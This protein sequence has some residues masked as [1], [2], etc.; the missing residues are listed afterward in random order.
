MTIVDVVSY[1]DLTIGKTYTVLGVLMDKSTGEKLLVDGK[2]I[3]SKAEFTAEEENGTVE[4]PFTFDCSRLAG[5]SIVAFETSYHDGLELA[6][7]AD[8]EDEAQTVTFNPKGG[9]LIQKTA[10]DNQIEGISFLVTGDGYSETFAT[11]AQG[12]IYIQNLTPGEYT[13]SEIE[14]ELTSRYVIEDEKTVMVTTGDEPAT[15]AFNNK[16]R[17]GSL[18][19]VK[20]EAGTDTRLGGASFCVKDAEG[21][22][23]AEGKT[24]TDG[25]LLFEDLPWGA[26]TVQEIYAPEGYILDDSEREFEIGEETAEVEIT[27]E[28]KK[29]T[30][31]TTHTDVPKTGDTRVNPWLVGLAMVAMLTG[32][33]SLLFYLIKKRRAK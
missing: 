15:V 20:V 1:S 7:H 29:D 2:E 19:I 12:R 30:P 14:N 13:V 24:D 6:V 16:L 8:I 25:E 17:R 22:V 3:T 4:V 32:A 5:K 9:L 27:V 28:N 31:D 23:V 26:Y 21:Q 18:H 33:G 11:D 10:E